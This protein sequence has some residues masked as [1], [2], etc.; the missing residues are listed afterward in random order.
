[1][2]TFLYLLVGT[3]LLA[4]TPQNETPPSIKTFNQ[5][6]ETAIKQL[7]K[8]YRAAWMAGDSVQ[9]LNKLSDEVRMIRPGDNA[10]PIIGKKAL[11][12]FWFP[13][14]DLSYPIFKYD[15]S[16]EEIQGSG[17]LAFLQGTS[18]LGWC[19]LENGV[20]RD[21]TTN[22]S[23]YLTVLKREENTWRI[24]RQIYNMKASDYSRK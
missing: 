23:E 20:F 10:A 19:I 4:C 11:A 6:D 7:M 15:I 9:V 1:M 12:E 18:H 16:N 8:D 2:K 24:F 17:D 3:M 21:S 5:E 13:P 22:V 14:S